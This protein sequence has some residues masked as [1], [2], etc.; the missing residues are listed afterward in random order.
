MTKETT[1]NIDTHKE[2]FLK[3]SIQVSLNGL[4]FC[5]LDT[6][7]NTLVVSERQVFETILTPYG[8]QKKLSALLGQYDLLERL[9][10]EVFVIHRNSLFSLVPKPLFDEEELANYLKFNAKILANDHIAFDEIP[11]YDMVN[12]YVPFTNINNYIFDLYG[13]FEFQHNGTVMVNSLL[14]SQNGSKEA[15]FYVHVGEKQM[16]VTVIKQKQLILYNSFNFVTKEDFLYYLLF[17]M[18]QLQYDPQNCLLKLFGDIEEDDECYELC[19]QYVKNIS[20]FIPSNKGYPLA[21]VNQDSID[22]AMLS[23]L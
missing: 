7:K 23:T 4:S 9:F 12:V 18:E 21:E 16:D 11:S 10:S 17:T 5:V 15:I 8:L 14:K 3:L 19:Y 20:I 13:E 22:F 2:D 1:N 6:L